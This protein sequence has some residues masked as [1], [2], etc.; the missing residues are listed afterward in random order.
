MHVRTRARVCVHIEC[1]VI[2][3][4]MYKCMHACMYAHMYVCMYVCMY[5]WNVM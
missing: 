5:V 3:V 4:C 1:N 2:Y